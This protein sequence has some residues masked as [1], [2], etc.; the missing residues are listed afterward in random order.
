MPQIVNRYSRGAGLL[1]Q[2]AFR[3]G[4]D[5]GDISFNQAE[6]SGRALFRQ[7][8]IGGNAGF[9]RMNCLIASA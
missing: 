5:A 2:L 6:I 8:K 4:E 1:D 7:V 9:D 3:R